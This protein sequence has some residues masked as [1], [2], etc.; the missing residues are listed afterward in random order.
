MLT[1]ASC[2][3]E[4]SAVDGGRLRSMGAADRLKGIAERNFKAGDDVLPASP[5]VAATLYVLCRPNEAE[6]LFSLP[7]DRYREVAPDKLT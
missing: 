2:P 4:A 5:E 6:A 3:S 7:S 1:V